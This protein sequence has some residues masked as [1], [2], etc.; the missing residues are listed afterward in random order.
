MTVVDETVRETHRIDDHEGY[1][2][3]VTIR[4]ADSEI[5][6][7]ATLRGQFDPIDGRYHWYGRLASHDRL[8]RLAGR[9]PAEVTVVTS[10]GASNGRMGDA[11]FWGRLRVAGVG[12]PPFAI[13]TLD[14]DDPGE[15]NVLAA[16]GMPDGFREDV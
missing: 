5:E 10:E 4:V 14:G 1:A 7:Q 13:A 12:R 9:A 16:S 3:P 8:A 15:P 11:D 2:G 6:V